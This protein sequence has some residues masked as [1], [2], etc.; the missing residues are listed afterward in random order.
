MTLRQLLLMSFLCAFETYFFNDSLYEGDYLFSVFWG[1]LLVRNIQRSYN[2]TKFNEALL[3][4]T[5]KKD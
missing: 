4:A 5:K 1:I 3:S 2:I